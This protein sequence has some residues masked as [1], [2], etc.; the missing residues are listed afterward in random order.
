MEFVRRFVLGKELPLGP[1][2]AYDAEHAAAVLDRLL[3]LVED[4]AI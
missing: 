4:E 3:E 1:T 2:E